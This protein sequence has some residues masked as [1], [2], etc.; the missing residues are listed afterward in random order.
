MK[1]LLN[2]TVEALHHAL[3][4]TQC[5][6]CGYEDCKAYAQAIVL[7]DAQINQCPPGG[8]EGVERLASLTGLAV[9]T[10][11]PQFGV[12]G[13]RTVAFIDEAWCI[14]CTLCI[15]ACPV[16]AISGTNKAMHTVDETVC[17]GCELC[18]PACPV[19]CIELSN[20]SGEL[21]GWAAWSSQWQA[22]SLSRYEARSQ[23]LAQ[24][25]QRHVRLKLDQAQD[26]LLDLAQ[27]SKIKDA[28]V[29]D[30]KRRLIEAAMA[31]ARA[32]LQQSPKP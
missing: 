22:Q 3:P 16:D 17:T 21:T 7:G 2:V 12:E 6:R 23:R 10:L 32:K 8:Q 1:P 26:K 25:E 27:H 18:I 24:E 29:L 4:Q 28:E 20:E 31:K 14:G 30:T 15:K 19:D 13:P 11:D 9:Q 5:K